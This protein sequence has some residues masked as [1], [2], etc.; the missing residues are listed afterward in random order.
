MAQQSL[1]WSRLSLECGVHSAEKS[2]A[3]SNL[4]SL[5]RNNRVSEREF[6][7]IDETQNAPGTLFTVRICCLDGV[8]PF[9]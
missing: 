7:A 9:E 6:R 2:T 3:S 4:R 5:R 8:K 1:I